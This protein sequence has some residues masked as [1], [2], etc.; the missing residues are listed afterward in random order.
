[1]DAE[2]FLYN[3]SSLAL[4]ILRVFLRPLS[5]LYCALSFLR[6]VLAPQ[7][8]PPIPTISVGNLILGGTGKTPFVIA[9]AAKLENSAVILRGYKRKTSGLIVV[10]KTSTLA[11]VGDEALE[12]FS[13]LGQ[14]TLVIVSRDRLS[15]IKKAAQ[16]GAKIAILDDGF[17]HRIKKFD[18]LLAPSKDPRHALCLPAGGYRMPPFMY[19]YAH[20]VLRQNA[21]FTKTVQI[22]GGSRS[23]V[24]VT[25]IANPARLDEFL[26]PGIQKFYF[27]DHH[28]FT[29]PELEHILRQTKAQSIL[30]TRKD[31]VKMQT[32]GLDSA[33]FSILELKLKIDEAVLEKIRHY[34]KEANAG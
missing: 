3:R 32:L 28:A 23:M 13:A 21:G 9:L 14:A 31:L 27:L 8:T 4:E 18:I 6:F 12:Y 11:E 7:K 5:A 10:S 33:R 2:A 15:G 29:A 19:K 20:L 30:T 22:L 16:L 25:A 26:P 1:M 34:I 24:L 17:R